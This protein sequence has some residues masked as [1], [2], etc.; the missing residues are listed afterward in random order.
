[1]RVVLF[2]TAVY[3]GLLLVFLSMR[4]YQLTATYKE[5]IENRERIE[6]LIVE[7]PIDH[8]HTLFSRLLIGQS[9][10]VEHDESGEAGTYELVAMSPCNPRIHSCN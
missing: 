4:Q 7:R 2:T 1:M 5:R 3:T 6:R 8:R 10:H 9:S